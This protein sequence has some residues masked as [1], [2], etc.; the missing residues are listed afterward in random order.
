MLAVIRIENTAHR[1][2]SVIAGL[3]LLAFGCSSELPTEENSNQNRVRI[4]FEETDDILVNPGMGFTTFHRLNSDM[5]RDQYPLTS[6]AYYRW[7]WD[8]IEREPGQIPFTQIDEL[9]QQVQSQGQKLAFRIMAVNIGARVPQWLLDL[10]LTGVTFVDLVDSTTQFM[11]NFDDPIFL[12]HA[13]RLIRALGEKYN[14][15]AAIDHV[16]IGFVGH[17]GEWHT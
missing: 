12:E 14:G 1:F 6:V 13:E 11:P 16:D 8:E 17:W 2:N 10:G 5:P 9:L 3:M 4:A 7:Y 15:H